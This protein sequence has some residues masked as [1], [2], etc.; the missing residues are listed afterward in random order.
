LFTTPDNEP[1]SPD[2]AAIARAYGVT[3]V[4]V[5]KAEDFKPELE[6]ALSS[7]KPYLLDVRMENAPVVTAG[8]WNIND[9]YVKRGDKKPGRVWE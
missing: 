1:Y 9:I 8:C 5:T 7:N 2:F 4:T 3:G 6:K